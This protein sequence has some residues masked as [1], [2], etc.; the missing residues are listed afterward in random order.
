MPG[1]DD[2][3][4]ELGRNITLDGA[5]HSGHS[6]EISSQLFFAPRGLWSEGLLFLNVKESSRGFFLSTI[7]DW[8]WALIFWCIWFLIVLGK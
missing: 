4:L 5:E 2:S 7:L 1:F 8:C 3:Q 6:V